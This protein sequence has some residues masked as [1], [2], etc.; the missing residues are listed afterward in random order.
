MYSTQQQ[1]ERERQKIKV[2]EEEQRIKFI[3]GLIFAPIFL[4]GWMPILWIV[5]KIFK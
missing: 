5:T 3:Q 2:R 1:I 4:L